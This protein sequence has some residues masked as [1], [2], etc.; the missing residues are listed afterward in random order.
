MFL[1]ILGRKRAL[2]DPLGRPAHLGPSPPRSQPTSS[3]RALLS[4]SL[5]EVLVP[6]GLL[7]EVSPEADSSKHREE[8]LQP[9][10]SHADRLHGCVRACVRAWKPDVAEQH[11]LP[12]C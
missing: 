5:Q 2:M 9:G 7:L 6:A 10:S 12:V 4:R 3:L 8:N 11:T 1:W